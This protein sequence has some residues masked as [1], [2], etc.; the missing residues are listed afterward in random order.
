MECKKNHRGGEKRENTLRIDFYFQCLK[1]VLRV[2]YPSTFLIVHV[3]GLRRSRSF[4]ECSSNWKALDQ[5]STLYTELKHGTVFRI[6]DDV[7]ARNCHHRLSM[8]LQ[9]NQQ[10]GR[11]T[12]F[13]VCDG[14]T[15][16]L[17]LVLPQLKSP[18]E[19][20]SGATNTLMDTPAFIFQCVCARKKCS[21]PVAPTFLDTTCSISKILNVKFTYSF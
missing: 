3:R 9:H 5:E 12:W 18:Q 17:L 21:G 20:S 15:C 10:Q 16:K 14:N 11:V 4:Q 19:P 1:F 13:H 7:K 8:C 2:L 6:I